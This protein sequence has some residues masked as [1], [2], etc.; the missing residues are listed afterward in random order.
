MRVTASFSV[1]GGRRTRIWRA[2][3]MYVENY[4]I[5]DAIKATKNNHNFRFTTII[6]FI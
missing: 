6:Y 3:T 2:E 4:T 5:F 1:S